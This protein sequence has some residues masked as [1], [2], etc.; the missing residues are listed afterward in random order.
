[1]SMLKG[2]DGLIQIGPSN[3]PTTVGY[4]NEIEINTEMTITQKGP[5]IGMNSIEKSGGPRTSKGTLSADF[6]ATRNA[7]QAKII[8]LIEAGTLFRIVAKVQNGTDGYTYTSPETACS[9]LGI[10]GNGESG[11]TGAFEIEDM[12]GYTLAASA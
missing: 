1:M 6:P 9:S 8:E 2:S 4:I 5:W 7:G 3:A 11:W 12:S 10:T